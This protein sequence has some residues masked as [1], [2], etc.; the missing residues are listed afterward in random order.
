LDIDTHWCLA[1]RSIDAVQDIYASATRSGV[2]LLILVNSMEEIDVQAIHKALANSVRRDILG[3]MREP[4]T[5]LSGQK[6]PLELGVC[7]GSIEERCDL[8]Q[9]TVSEHLA[10]LQRA[11]LLISRRIGACVLL[12][13]NDAAIKAFIEYMQTRL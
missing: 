11:G 7:A 1:I 12:R 4:E 2:A 6:L 3:W 8:S 10:V 9:S 13:R 5:H